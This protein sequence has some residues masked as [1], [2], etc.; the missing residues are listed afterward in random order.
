LFDFFF[1]GIG[2]AIDA[3]D[4]RIMEELALTPEQ[5]QQLLEQ[6][7][8]LLKETEEDLS[9]L[10]RALLT[11]DR[12]ELERLLREAASQEA[13]AADSF[14][15]TPYTRMAARLQLDG[16]QREIER[17]KGMLQLRGDKD[18]DSR[19]VLRYLDERM[20]EFNRLLR[21]IIRQEQ[22]KRG[23][24]PTDTSRRS[25]LADKSFAFYTEDDI[26]R[27]NDA[28]ARLAQRL[29]SRLSVRRKKAARGRFNVKE[30]LR[31]N[32]QYGGVPFNIQIDRRKKTK[33]QVMILCDI[34]DSVLNASRFMLQF[35]YSVQDL[36][37]KVRSFVFVSDIGEVTKLFE[38]NEIHRAV[39]TALKGDVIDVF[40]HSNF[41]RAFEKFYKNYFAAVTSKTTVLIIGDGRNNYNRPN[42]WVLKEIQQKAKQ[43]IWLNPEN[44]ITWG[45]GDSEMPCYAPYC[46]VAEECR[47]LSQ[48]SR[49]VDLIAP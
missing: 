49:I 32:L 33:P 43:L 3:A 27:M 21:Q 37:A 44:Q 28:V 8:R 15:F 16:V 2:Q 4:R 45:V 31:K 30:T 26:R 20:R 39:E 19:D 5:F 12:G 9:P 23:L 36:Y 47:N 25:S 40:S 24:E 6:V 14:R 38:E 34:S 22:R 18:E 7:E 10:T 17:F 35:V 29:K 41:G 13:D 1:L 48:L 46:D 11:G 42:G